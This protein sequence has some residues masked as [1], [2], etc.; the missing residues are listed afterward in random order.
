MQTTIDPT[1]HVYD[2]TTIGLHWA[3]ALLVIVLWVMGRTIHFLPRGPLRIDA[4]SMHILFGITLAAV[5]IARIFWRSVHGRRLPAA[6]RGMFQV[7][8]KTVHWLLYALLVTVVTLGVINVF[9]HAFP[10]FNVWHFA[11]L[12]DKA[13][14][15]R[16]NSWHNLAANVIAALALCHAVAALFHH[17]VIRD[18]VLGRMWPGRRAAG[19]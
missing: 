14:G 4:W 2:K 11:Q 9:A 7:L 12:G 16:I 8:A 15:R 1:R 17:Y 3:T 6:D 10:L 13:F 19:E 18:A 5:L